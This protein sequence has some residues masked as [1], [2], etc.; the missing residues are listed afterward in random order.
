MSK[1]VKCKACGKE[2]AKGTKCVG[3]GHDQ[4]NFFGKHKILT[5]LAVVVLLVVISNI[6]N[7]TTTAPVASTSDKSVPVTAEAPVVKEPVVKEF[8]AIGEAVKSSDATVTVT[9]VEKSQGSEYDKPKSGM[10]WVIATVTITNSGTGEISYNPYDFKMQNSKG[11][12]T[13][14]TFAMVNQDTALQSGSLASNGSITGTLIF[15]QPKNDKA[16]VL[17]YSG[18]IFSK[19]VQFKLN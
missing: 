6:G 9:K 2:I 8:Y 11:Q 10:E 18:A 7:G 3:C 1:M 16:L 15:E 17:K 4:R 19:G 13:D 12:I 14:G 5:G